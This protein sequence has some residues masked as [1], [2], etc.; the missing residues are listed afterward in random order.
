MQSSDPLV[1]QVLQRPES[2]TWLEALTA[3]FF[4]PKAKRSCLET[5]RAAIPSLLP[6]LDA[7][8]QRMVVAGVTQE[9]CRQA[10]QLSRTPVEL[11]PPLS[12]TELGRRI[13]GDYPFPVA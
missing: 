13:I 7:E 12:G 8:T 6:G 5:V 11:V 4:D 9:L 2:Q 3:V 1:Q 10:S